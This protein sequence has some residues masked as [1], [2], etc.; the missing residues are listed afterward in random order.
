MEDLIKINHSICSIPIFY[1]KDQ[2]NELGA[3]NCPKFKGLSY[4]GYVTLKDGKMYNMNGD[5]VILHP[6]EKYRKIGA[7]ISNTD[8]LIDLKINIF[9]YLQKLL[10][11]LDQTSLDCK[12]INLSLSYNNYI[13]LT[14]EYDKETN[15]VDNIDMIFDFLLNIKQYKYDNRNFW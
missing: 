11:Q 4:Q 5:E 9:K 8:N 1:N 14:V 2:Y 15:V 10:S 6:N 13:T 3:I 7:M 12:N